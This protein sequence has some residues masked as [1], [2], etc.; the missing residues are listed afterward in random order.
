MNGLI[1]CKQLWCIQNGMGSRSPGL[2]HEL[3][4]WPLAWRTCL[5][6]GTTLKFYIHKNT[7]SLQR[8]KL[9]IV[10]CGKGMCGSKPI[11]QNR[12]HLS[13]KRN[14]LPNKCRIFFL[15]THIRFNACN[16]LENSFLIVIIISCHTH[17]SVKLPCNSS[18]FFVHIGSPQA[19][20]RLNQ[21]ITVTESHYHGWI[22]GGLHEVGMRFAWGWH[23]VCPRLAWGWY[24]V[25][26][27]LPW[28][29]HKVGM[30]F[31]QGWH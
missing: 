5:F 28:G 31:S 22:N 9:D 11:N 6:P 20:R 21:F 14:R 17:L 29:W 12:L 23:E 18:V 24:E 13:I 15:K 30:R 25:S 16:A 26:M 27:R 4:Q 2:F 3:L 10:V 1:S 7:L 19:V 8:W